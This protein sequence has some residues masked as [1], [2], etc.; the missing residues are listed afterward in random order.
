MRGQLK[1][2]EI[3]PYL[4]DLLRLKQDH[5]SEE[6]WANTRELLQEVIMVNYLSYLFFI[7]PQSLAKLPQVRESAVFQDFFP[8]K[9]RD[10]A[11]GVTNRSTSSQ[12]DSTVLS[13]RNDTQ[14]NRVIFDNVKN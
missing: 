2:S 3:L 12:E 6:N 8:L 9:S 14:D 4:E 7:N 10:Q 13:S 1:N 11:L 5:L